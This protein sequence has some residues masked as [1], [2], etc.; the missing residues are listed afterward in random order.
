[1]VYFKNRDFKGLPKIPLGEKD[2]YNFRG[3]W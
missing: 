1:M 2:E 3:T